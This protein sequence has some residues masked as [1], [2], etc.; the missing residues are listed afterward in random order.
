MEDGSDQGIYPALDLM[1][2]DSATRKQV[3]AEGPNAKVC[4]ARAHTCTV[5]TIFV[6]L[7][8]TRPKFGG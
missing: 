8:P 4:A 1:E 3:E 7:V 2:W 6:S 5:S